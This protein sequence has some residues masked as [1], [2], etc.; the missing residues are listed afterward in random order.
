LAYSD[1]DGL[2]D[3]RELSRQDDCSLQAGGDP[4]GDIVSNEDEAQSGTNALDASS[5]PAAQL[6]VPIMQLSWISE[7]GHCCRV[8]ESSTFTEW[9][10]LGEDFAGDCG[11]ILQDLPDAN[12]QHF[13]RVRISSEPAPPNP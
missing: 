10:P 11:K 12:S 9:T 8:E 4:D 13:Y 7:P 3:Q 1:F 5:R 2:S 6:H